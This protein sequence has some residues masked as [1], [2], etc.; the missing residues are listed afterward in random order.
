MKTHRELIAEILCGLAEYYDKKLTAGQIAMYVEDLSSLDP[1]RLFEA[2]QTYRLDPENNRFPLPSKLRSM[3][4]ASPADE[5]RESAA[6]I[7]SAVFKYGWNNPHPART[8]IGET[9]WAVVQAQGGWLAV[10]ETLTFQNQGMLQAQWRELAISLKRVKS[11]FREA[12]SGALPGI[13][14]AGLLPQMPKGDA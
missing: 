7:V 6:K 3:L 12:N 1:H 9:G 13:D 8:Y 11:S 10:C 5:G 4:S 2:V 14:I